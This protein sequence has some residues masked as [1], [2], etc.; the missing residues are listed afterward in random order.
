MAADDWLVRA[1]KYGIMFASVFVVQMNIVAASVAAS[2][3]AIL[4]LTFPSIC[5]R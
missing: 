3:F 2:V 5:V 4:D 1:L